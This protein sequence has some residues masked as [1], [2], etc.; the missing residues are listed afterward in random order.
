MAKLEGVE[1]DYVSVHICSPDVMPQVSGRRWKVLRAFVLA[2]VRFKHLD[3]D[4]VQDLDSLLLD[5]Q[6]SPAVQRH[7]HKSVTK[8]AIA[9]HR[10]TEELFALVTRGSSDDLATLSDLLAKDPLLRSSI[11]NCKNIAGHTLLH[12]AALNGHL[13]VVQ[14]LLE[15][16]ADLH[17]ASSVS[18]TEEETPLEVAVRWNHLRVVDFLLQVGSFSRQ[19]LTNALKFCRSEELR[20]RLKTVKANRGNHAV[21]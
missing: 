20:R 1:G 15:N 3:V 4:V 10:R 8:Q 11:V 21:V 6:Q 12:E 9:L 5:V 19:E 14:L 2:F 17:L 18:D 16:S 7:F 13:G